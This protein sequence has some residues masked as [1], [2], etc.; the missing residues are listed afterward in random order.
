[1]MCEGLDDPRRQISVGRNRPTT[2]V[3]SPAPN[4]QHDQRHGE[5][6]HDH[7][8]GKRP[9]DQQQ[10]SHEHDRGNGARDR[11]GERVKPI[12]DVPHLGVDGVL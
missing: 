9:G 5:S 11:L 6:P 10:E 4:R 3:V 1:M 2:E 8:Q 7:C 12:R